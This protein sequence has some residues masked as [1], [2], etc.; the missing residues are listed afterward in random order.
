VLAEFCAE[1]DIRGQ[2][3]NLNWFWAAPGDRPNLRLVRRRRAYPTGPED[4]LCVFDLADLFKDHDEP[5]TRIQQSRY[6]ILNSTAEGGLRQAE[7]AAYYGQHDQPV[8]VQ[9]AY[10]D[11]KAASVKVVRITD[12]VNLQRSVD[13]SPPWDAVETIEITS[14]SDDGSQTLSWQIVVRTGHEQGEPNQFE[15]SPPDTSFTSVDFDQVV[16]QETTATVP[17]NGNGVFNAEFRTAMDGVDLRVVTLEELRDSHTGDWR[18]GAS[19]ADT[20]LDPQVVYYYALFKR[21]PNSHAYHSEQTWRAS[22]MAI[23]HYGVDECLFQLLPAVHKR[24][25]EPGPGQQGRP[26]QLRRFLQVF[27]LTLDHLRGQAEGL[28]ARHDVLDVQASRLPHLAQWIGWDLDRTLDELAQRNE[29]LFAPELYRTVGTIPNIRALVNHLT[30]WDCR[31]KEFVHNVVLSNRPE[32]LNIWI[33]R[34]SSNGK[35]SKPT[36]PLSLDF[37]YEGR[38]AAAR[39]A[40]D[41]LWLFYHTLRKGQWDIWYKTLTEFAIAKEFQ[42]DLNA[43][44]VSKR[45]RQAFE[46]GGS[47][48]APHATIE[49]KDGL[50]LVNDAEN[51]ENYTVKEE[52][53]GLKVYRWAPSRPL[54]DRMQLDK[55]PT[56]AVRGETLLVFWDSYDEANHT[57][58]IDFRLRDA[59]GE[60]SPITSFVDP[61]AEIQPERRRPCAVVDDQGG[62]W[63]FWLEKAGSHWQ[64]KYN[65][66]SGTD[67]DAESLRDF[68]ESAHDFPLDENGRSPQW[69]VFAFAD[70]ESH[71][72]VFWARRVTAPNN[73]SDPTETTAGGPDRSPWQIAYRYTELSD[74]DAWSSIH[75]V[76]QEPS[77]HDYR[78]PAAVWDETDGSVE[79]FCTS[80]RDGSW[81]VWHGPLNHWNIAKQVKRSPY[82]QRDPLPVTLADGTLLVYR[83]N[84]I[85]IPRSAVSGAPQS[86]DTRYAGC[87]TVD[88][89]NLSKLALR[90]RFEDFQSYTYDAGD[91]GERTNQDWYARDTVGVFLTPDTEDATLNQ[92][93]RHRIEDFL[94]RFLPIQVRAVFIVEPPVYTELVYTYGFEDYE[95]KRVIV[96]QVF[97][98]T[99][100][101]PYLGIE[102]SYRD[103]VPGWVWVHSW[104]LEY[105]DHRTVDFTTTPIDTK[106]RTW[107]IGLEPGGGHTVEFIGTSLRGEYRDVL[108][109]P[110]GSLLYDSGWVPNTIVDECRISLAQ[111]M[112]RE[113]S[114][115]ILHLAVGRGLETWDTEGAPAPEP[116]TTDLINQYPV[117]IPVANPNPATGSKLEL[118]YWGDEQVSDDPTSCLQIK[119]TLNPGYPQPE[120]GLSTYPLRNFGLFGGIDA[121]PD[122]YM[123]NCVRHPVIHKPDTATLVRIIRLYF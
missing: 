29:I 3:I 77:D 113:L 21:I 118:A 84:Q 34:R 108:R 17:E 103:I 7:L 48:L 91:N 47:R 46:N 122:P 12:V 80:N 19:V 51:S 4:G 66:H 76:P 62:L 14:M 99:I 88:T 86:L 10:Y 20:G 25:D 18:R 44:N 61:D 5:W 57:W 49:K 9:V 73:E 87:T 71:L 58:R 93:T 69:D 24:Y 45:L 53:G 97:D 110:D 123:I 107:H 119:A 55:H 74:P 28:R 1:S 96:E 36:E 54:T 8:E 2:R 35:W 63:L 117:T 37:A 50:W 85:L 64:L 115:G 102:D 15:W 92:H 65:S 90:G 52:T 114:A 41:V 120:S 38:P 31:V 56:A 116:D 33:A 98:S 82:S 81:S 22:A 59:A 104:S 72:W 67:W 78:E 16:V 89:R 70:P 109:G 75:T 43:A 83:S 27:G 13:P 121:D 94:R 105:L 100:P 111:F 40:D 26:G 32:R 112:K 39:D 11:Q 30:G 95:P 68:L 23:G 6:L 101:E 42:D 79:I 106:F 60:W